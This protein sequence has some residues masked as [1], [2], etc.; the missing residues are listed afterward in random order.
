MLTFADLKEFYAANFLAADVK[1]VIF[2]VF[3]QKFKDDA[4][5][6]TME[7]AATESDTVGSGCLD[8]GEARFQTF[9][10]HH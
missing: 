8:R 1:P 10:P 7:Q 6:L 5:S 9:L 3:S 2:R 4:L